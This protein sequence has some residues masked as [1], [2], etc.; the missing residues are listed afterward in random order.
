MLIGADGMRTASC[1]GD[2]CQRIGAHGLGRAGA[3]E[4]MTTSKPS[5]YSLLTVRSTRAS[6]E[7]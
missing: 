1:R 5:F 3:N 7:R 2:G 6:R 4:S